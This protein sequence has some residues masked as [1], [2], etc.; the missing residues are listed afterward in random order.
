MHTRTSCGSRHD[1]SSWRNVLI[2]DG[3]GYA[4]SLR[5]R[6]LRVCGARNDQGEADEQKRRE[7]LK[8]AA[9]DGIGAI[10]GNESLEREGERENAEGRARQSRND[11]LD[12]TDGVPGAFVGSGSTPSWSTK[13]LVTGLYDNP[14]AAGKAYQDLTT[15]HGYKVR[16][17]NYFRRSCCLISKC[18]RLNGSIDRSF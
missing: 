9:K 12:Q 11:V 8:G 6:V 17:V 10:T 4:R 14:A 16:G 5:S 1:A 2:G 13:H 15:R 3:V 18:Y 7:R